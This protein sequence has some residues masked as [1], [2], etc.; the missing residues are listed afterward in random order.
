MGC[1]VVA[2]S[3]DNK[4]VHK[5]WTETPRNKG[6][7]GKMEIPMLA[8]TTHRIS[9]AFNVYIA[10]EGLALRG[11]FIVDGKGIL[12]HVGLNDLPIGR[13]VDEVLRLVAAA[14]FTDEHGEVCP[15]KWKP[16]QKGVSTIHQPSFV[17]HDLW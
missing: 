12:R 13:S 7:L 2:A 9:K 8:D 1:E 3:V 4:F 15:A 16:G 14:K 6:G 10:N 17:I 5:V 11:T